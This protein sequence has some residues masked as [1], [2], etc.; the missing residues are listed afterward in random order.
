MACMWPG[1]RGP[2]T[3]VAIV[4]LGV[5][6]A[7]T[8]G[9]D[10]GSALGPLRTDSAGVEM[11]LNRITATAVPVFAT[12]DSLPTLRL[13]SLDGRPEEQFGTVADVQPLPDGGVAVL[14]GQAAEIRLFD[15]EG[16]YQT[17]LGSKGRGPGEL[18]RPNELALLPGDT[19]AVYDAAAM[20]ITHFGPDGALGRI[21]TLQGNR[22][23]V[24]LASFL[25]DG[26]LVGQSPWLGPTRGS[27]PGQEP[28][29]VRDT[30]VLTLFTTDGAI[31][32]TVDVLP[33]REAIQTID[34]SERSVSISKRPPAFGRTN[35]FAPHPEGV[36]SS[37]ND[38]FELRLREPGS[39]RLLRMIRARGLEQPVTD[40]LA[41]EVHDRAL[42]EAE[43]AADRRRA[44]TWYA[45]SPRPET[46][47]AYDRIVVDDHARLWVRAWSALDPAT[48]WWVFDAGGELLGVVDV[49]GGT[50]ITS[51][52]CRT[53]WGVEQDHLDVSYVVRYALQGIE[54]VAHCD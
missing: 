35:L 39:G 11:V 53:V 46:L 10:A 6:G 7:C 45:L 40:E 47:P 20:R 36:W 41:Q 42:A 4:I 34:V 37:T 8:G 9:A 43:T 13:G 2:V 12:L 26:R 52:R 29:F 30:V 49:P 25:P 16:E 1:S 38:R 24:V 21:I 50:T 27:P 33:G 28:T 44:A 54:A 23:R 3:V 18:Q 48:R 31:D 32:D 51:V 22:A 14:D 17:S 19:L 15:S 5:V